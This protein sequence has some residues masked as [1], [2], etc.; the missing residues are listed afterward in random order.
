MLRLTRKP[1]SLTGLARAEGFEPISSVLE[2]A[3]L[4]IELRPFV[5]V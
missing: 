1:L 5:T 4:P 2:T 3:D